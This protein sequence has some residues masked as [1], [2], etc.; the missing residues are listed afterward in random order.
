MKKI[1][2]TV[3][4]IMLT[5][6]IGFVGQS[7]LPQTTTA[8]TEENMNYFEEKSYC[9][10]TLEDD[11]ADNR[12]LVTLTT[13]V[14]KKFDSYSKE[15]FSG[16]SC[17]SVS[18]LTEESVQRVKRQQ[19]E[20]MTS[21]VDVRDFKT[22]LSLEL[23]EKS[24]ENVLETI[25]ELEKR[26][27]VLY[28][29][30]DY[31]M[32]F[33]AAPNPK[34]TYYNSQW[35]LNN[36]NPNNPF[37]QMHNAWDI[38]RGKSSV[39][40]AIMDSGIQAN[41]TD[42]SGKVDTALSRDFTLKSPYTI[43]SVTD[44]EG[45]GTW[46]AGIV[47]AKGIDVIG[48]APDVTLVSLRIA[49][50]DKGGPSANKDA[51][52]STAI[53]A[54]DYCAGKN[55]DV[56][57]L[58]AG[59]YGTSSSTLKSK[60]EACGS[61]VV[62]AAGNG[63]T[64]N[65]VGT[66]NNNIPVYPASFN[67]ANIISVGATTNSDTI[68]S[69]SNYG[70]TSV[71]I[72]APGDNIIS[73]FPTNTHLTSPGTSA[74][75]PMCAGVAALI[76]SIFPNMSAEAVKAA[77][78]AG[79]DIPNVGGTN[80]LQGRC[81]TNGRLNAYKALNCAAKYQAGRGLTVSGDFNG[82]GLDDIAAFTGS[83][84]QAELHVWYSTG[85]SFAYD[86]IWWQSNNFNV[87]A[88]T[89]RVVAGNFASISGSR[90]DIA[91]FYGYGIINGQPIASIYMF[92]SRGTYFD[93]LEWNILTNFNADAITG[94][95]VAGNFASISGSRDDIAVIYAY[96]HIASLYVFPSRNTYFDFVEWSY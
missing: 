15:D 7:I 4:A 58:S 46:V 11:F 75:A 47:A 29:E 36:S 61:L 71:D 95:V 34:P 39:K 3:L 89:G 22:V 70:S 31:I 81:V 16:I 87:N 38:T 28:A 86:G 80:P 72:F 43:S 73:T 67:S 92:P 69:F 60:I 9:S 96:Q 90:D 53:L 2:T 1:F 40:V 45:H 59:Y 68:T 88:I 10:A 42:L 26:D 19:L 63:E 55:F 77:I 62:C 48:V 25:R 54:F 32:T 52:I 84:V 82:D 74:A 13:E 44:P 51:F 49:N 57:N 94:R 66:N 6:S 21:D 41:H 5:I 78:L 24:K 76:K 17:V 14:S 85:S 64:N 56:I 93:F 18:D 33:F 79:V 8:Y 23:A 37:I 65:G 91:V 83:G 20:E 12:V 50:P 30:P 27:D 35:A